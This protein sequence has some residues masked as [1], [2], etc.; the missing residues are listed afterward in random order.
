MYA[1][2]IEEEA[3]RWLIMSDPWIYLVGQSRIIFALAGLRKGL[4]VEIRSVLFSVSSS[5]REDSAPGTLQSD[6]PNQ[7]AG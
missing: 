7:T 1:C 5:L 6:S 2:F 3:A 4:G